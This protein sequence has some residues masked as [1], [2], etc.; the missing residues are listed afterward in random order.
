MFLYR[1]FF[2]FLCLSLLGSCSTYRNTYRLQDV[3][4]S[5]MKITQNLVDVEADFSRRVSGT[6]Y[7]RMRSINAA[8]DNAYYNAIITNQIDV[9]VDPVYEIK[10]LR[11]R[12]TA[13]VTGFPGTYKKNRTADAEDQQV[14]DQQLNNFKSFLSLEP[15]VKEDS[16]SVYLLTQPGGQATVVEEKEVRNVPD[17][18]TRFENFVTQKTGEDKVKVVVQEKTTQDTTSVYADAYVAPTEEEPEL[19]KAFGK[20]NRILSLSA[21][22]YTPL[23]FEAMGGVL[24]DHEFAVGKYIGVGYF[25]GLGGGSTSSTYISNISVNIGYTTNFHFYQLIADKKNK[26][27][28]MRSDKIDMYMGVNLGTSVV[29]AVD[30]DYGYL[31][32]FDV[33][34]LGGAHLGLRYYFTD[35]IALNTEV[36]YG[37]NWLNMGVTFKL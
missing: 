12:H 34:F 10:T 16:R 23:S 4:D 24:Y 18:V 15:V 28:Q 36:G 33:T 20:R 27:R 19:P 30:T 5:Q 26:H 32:D 31:D 14:Y 2:I 25:A 7:T 17:L 1:N 22:G 11:N 35:R 3:A 37:K 29:M 9:L 8:K 21:G 13:S 6:S